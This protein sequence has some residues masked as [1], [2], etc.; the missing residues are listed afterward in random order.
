ML[1]LLSCPLQAAAQ[2]LEFV[3]GADLAWSPIDIAKAD[4]HIG[5]LNLRLGARHAS[6]FGLELDL[7][8]GLTDDEASGVELEL[9]GHGAL[10]LTYTGAFDQRTL[11]TLALGYGV[12]ELEGRTSD[13]DFPG[14][15]RFKGPAF[16]VRVEESLKSYPALRICGSFYS[17]FNDDDIRIKSFSIG[18]QYHF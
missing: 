11:M 15:E 9:R 5:L 12:T 16:A 6:G 2:A 4:Y 10:H 14:R 3:A 17:L 1:L 7:S 8:R 13:R 18:L